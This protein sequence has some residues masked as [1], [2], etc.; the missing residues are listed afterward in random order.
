VTSGLVREARLAQ[1]RMAGRCH[2]LQ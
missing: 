2:S 1:R